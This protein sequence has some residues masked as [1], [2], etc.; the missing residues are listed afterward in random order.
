MVEMSRTGQKIMIMRTHPHKPRHLNPENHPRTPTHTYR[1]IWKLN[2]ISRAGSWRG[3]LTH[4]PLNTDMHFLSFSRPP[5]LSPTPIHM[6]LENEITTPSLALFRFD[7]LYIA[8]RRPGEQSK[9]PD[10]E[11]PCAGRFEHSPVQTLAR[12]SHEKKN[13]QDNTKECI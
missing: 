1:P 7:F 12:P 6:E 11:N 4:H 5:T 2:T 8:A 3:L 9:R 13:H 10:L